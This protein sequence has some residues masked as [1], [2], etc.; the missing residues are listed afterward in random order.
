M[1]STS[2]TQRRS[3]RRSVRREP[4][5]ADDVARAVGVSRSAVSRTFTEGA[6]VSP[7]T[8]KKVLAAARSLKYRPNLFAR[9]LMT[10]RSNILGLAV[11]YLDNQY[12][13]DVVQRF[14]EEFARAGYRLLLFITHGIE[15]PDP[16]L[17][18]LLKY[19]LDALV[20]ASSSVSSRLARECRD[21]GVPVL[22]FNHVDPEGEVPSVATTNVLGG[23]TVAAYLQAAEHKRFGYIAGFEADSTSYE[24]ETGFT[25][26]L[27]EQ[28][29]AAPYRA[30]SQFS[31]QGAE[32]ATRR[33]L[34][35]PQPP[36]AI[37]CV[38]DHMALAAIQVARSEFGREPGKDIS[39][40][41]FD[42]VPVA[43]WPCFQLTTY[44]Q[45]TGA[46]VSRSLQMLRSLLEHD[47]PHGPQERLPGELI[48]R[49][50][51]RIPGSG[52][53]VMGDGVRVWRPAHSL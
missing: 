42:N 33:L 36:D 44:S 10:R 30:E 31:F 29:F 23:R 18:E 34:S 51:A 5:T 9:S 46:M 25:A 11:S 35:L 17:E 28:G 1:K 14:S 53:L 15:G 24:R 47:S 16:L 13:P 27:I 40:I 50:S 22:M 20:L 21:A 43:A 48:V 19:R 38:N 41:G 37:F 7:A 3:T 2:K 52:V 26:H 8:R 49:G 4:V 39:I 45:P 12:Y 32:L 6:S